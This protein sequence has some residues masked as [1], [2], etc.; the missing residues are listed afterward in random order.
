MGQQVTNRQ[1]CVRTTAKRPNTTFS[2]ACRKCTT[3]GQGRSRDLL[4]SSLLTS[5]FQGPLLLSLLALRPE[6]SRPLDRKNK[7][8]P[9]R[10]AN[11]SRCSMDRRCAQPTS[12]GDER[13]SAGAGHH[14]ASRRALGSE[15]VGGRSVGRFELRLEGGCS[16]RERRR[17]V[18]VAVAVGGR[19]GHRWR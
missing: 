18:H 15:V 14:D 16:V 6:S 13:D 12:F 7:S 10:T 5:P 9:M 3:S 19:V 2:C 17:A 4:V 11:P 8:H 1:L